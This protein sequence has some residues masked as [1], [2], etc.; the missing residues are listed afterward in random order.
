[1]FKS[2]VTNKIL[3]IISLLVLM[4]VLLYCSSD[5]LSKVLI[6]SL[7]SIR[8][9][10]DLYNFLKTRLRKLIKLKNQKTAKGK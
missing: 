5:R 10:Y 8:I 2:E 7:L 3:S 1:M 4:A 6:I 9:L